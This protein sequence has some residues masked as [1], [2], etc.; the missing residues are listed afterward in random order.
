MSAK[1]F[2]KL[3][4]EKG[5]SQTELASFLRVDVRTISRWEN[6]KRK[7]PHIAILALGGL[8][9]KRKK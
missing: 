9:Q 5:Y 1:E 4:A 8:K 2:K 7:V 3:R 6:G